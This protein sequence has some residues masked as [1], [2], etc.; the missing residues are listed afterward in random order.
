MA[1]S[2]YNFFSNITSTNEVLKEKIRYFFDCFEI[3]ALLN[4]THYNFKC[5]NHSTLINSILFQIKF[6]YK[7]YRLKYI[8]HY[9]DNP[10][11][12][13]DDL[14]FNEN[15]QKFDV[16]LKLRNFIENHKEEKI[17]HSFEEFLVDF[18]SLKSYL[19]ENYFSV[20]FNKII[21]HLFDGKLL[22]QHFI[23]CVLY[24]AKLIVFDF[25]KNGSTV[26][27]LRSI[28]K[29]IL[30]KEL[31]KLYTS[32]DFEY[33]NLNGDDIGEKI[34]L[35]YKNRTIEE[36][37]NEV[38]LIYNNVRKS[39][40]LVF[41]IR[42]HF[43][44]LNELD[45][46]I[47]QVKFT[48]NP[49]HYISENIRYTEAIKKYHENY[50]FYAIVKIDFNTGKTTEIAKQKLKKAIIILESKLECALI[51][52][53]TTIVKDRSMQVSN[54][55]KIL[56]NDSDELNDALLNFDE[57]YLR[58]YYSNS[59]EEILLHLWSYMESNYLDAVKVINKVP[60]LI[61]RKY[62]ELSL[63]KIINFLVIKYEL[64]VDE[65]LSYSEVLKIIKKNKH[66][67]FKCILPNL[68]KLNSEYEK[69]CKLIK[70]HLFEIY[71]QR[72]MLVHGCINNEQSLIINI[73]A[74]KTYADFY[75]KSSKV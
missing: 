17:A 37:I 69:T 8:K 2:K 32:A 21:A 66:P 19:D 54:I 14:I 33:L 45:I 65:G 73:D 9:L 29:K 16:I 15:A 24:H 64:K 35:Y 63:E 26:S 23:E 53:N 56:D 49:P 52:E 71:E 40:E 75:M 1:C 62:F 48:S 31:E 70:N 10:L 5:E 3:S 28:I 34:K 42:P 59:N 47:L 11:L 74:F 61:R 50:C 38:K 72:N 4:N 7:N 68:N 57:Y 43:K 44:L 51:I 60:C 27:D 55:G 20:C 30:R 36:Q 41:L 46:E 6:G 25:I 12:L 67:L 39:Q 13:K 18:E 58:G 22:D